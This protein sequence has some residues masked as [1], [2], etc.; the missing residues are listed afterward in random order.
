MFGW[1]TGGRVCLLFLLFFCLD[2]KERKSQ[3]KFKSPAMVVCRT[4]L[5]YPGYD[6]HGHH[7]TRSRRTKFSI[8]SAGFVTYFLLDQ[9]VTKNQGC[10]NFYC[11]LRRENPRKQTRPLAADSNSVFLAQAHAIFTSLKTT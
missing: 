7:R 11:F 2:T 8:T 9:K 6:H 1:E 3:E 4:D 5:R 10:L